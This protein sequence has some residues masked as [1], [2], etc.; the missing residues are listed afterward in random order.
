MRQACPLVRKSC[1]QPVER[2]QAVAQQMHSQLQH[3][4]VHVT[5]TA[6]VHLQLGC[7]QLLALAHIRQPVLDGQIDLAGADPAECGCMLQASCRQPP[8]QLV[9]Q[10]PPFLPRGEGRQNR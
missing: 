9:A 2:E 10:L 3:L 6:A 1:S 7:G 4:S 5:Y 8:R